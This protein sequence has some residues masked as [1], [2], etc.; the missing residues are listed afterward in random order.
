[1]AGMS[2]AVLRPPPARLPR[3]AQPV[4]GADQPP[5]P[6][7]DH[8]LARPLEQDALTDAG[9]VIPP[10]DVRSDRYTADEWLALQ[11]GFRPDGA[12]VRADG[13]RWSALAAQDG[14]PAESDRSVIRLATIL[15]ARVRRHLNRPSVTG[16]RTQERLR[17]VLQTEYLPA[18]T[19]ID[20]VA[21][22]LGDPSWG[23][24]SFDED[25]ERFGDLPE[26]IPHLLDLHGR[27][28]GGERDRRFDH[29]RQRADRQVAIAIAEVLSDFF[30]T[31]GSED[32][33]AL[34]RAIHRGLRQEGVGFEK[35]S[36]SG[37]YFLRHPLNNAA[38]GL[39][40]DAATGLCFLLAGARQQPGDPTLFLDDLKP[41][42]DEVRLTLA[43]FRR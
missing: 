1:M 19:R 39:S 21:R 40:T 43:A 17:L 20:Q 29:L 5:A 35:G 38:N 23:T 30:S 25:L 12:V 14:L 41:L 27:W 34:T 33:G 18:R 11:D 32:A 7:R 8:G 13:E 16:D 22:A 2:T 36:S 4:P 9:V 15:G 24:R 37:C 3:Q 31:G 10:Y 28:G 6:P 26:A 42:R